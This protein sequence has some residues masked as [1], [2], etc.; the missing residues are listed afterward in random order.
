MNGVGIVCNNCIQFD[1]M[2]SNLTLKAHLHKA[3]SNPSQYLYE[4]QAVIFMGLL[5]INLINYLD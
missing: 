1:F 2:V 3:N 5:I 4:S